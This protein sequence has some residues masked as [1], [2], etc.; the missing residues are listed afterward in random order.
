MFKT[1]FIN[2]IFLSSE[3]RRWYGQPGRT[4]LSLT[5]WLGEDGPPG[6][7][8]GHAMV[9]VFTIIGFSYKSIIATAPYKSKAD[10]NYIF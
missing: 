8:V 10:K 6:P 7:A 4:I 2:S 1:Q 5:Q 9:V 3:H